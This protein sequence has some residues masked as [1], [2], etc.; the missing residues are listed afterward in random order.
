MHQFKK[1]IALFLL[2]VVSVFIVPKELVH[3]LI[4]HNDT[5]DAIPFPDAPTSIEHQHTHCEFLKLNVPLY[6]SEF[7][8]FDFILPTSYFVFE[9]FGVQ[10]FHA[11][12]F[13][14][15]ALRGPPTILIQNN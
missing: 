5:E 13:L 8:F 4:E 3:S 9:T 14:L 12:S 15:P 6:L 7:T 11:S 2:L 10:P 1:H